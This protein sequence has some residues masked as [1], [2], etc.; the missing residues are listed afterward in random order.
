MIIQLKQADY[1]D[2]IRQWK[3]EVDNIMREISRRP[4]PL[5]ELLTAL[6]Q[7][8]VKLESPTNKV[9]V[10]IEA[11][12]SGYRSSQERC[13]HREYRKVPRKRAESLV[14]AH[15]SH[16]FTDGTY[17]SYRVKI[18]KEREKKERE[19]KGYVDITNDLIKAIQ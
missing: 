11:Y 9:T 10:C 7:A 15:M 16:R 13:V 5:Q 17:N 4:E 8:L 1:L 19:I 18:L 6:R 14:Q 3:D 12:W 2:E